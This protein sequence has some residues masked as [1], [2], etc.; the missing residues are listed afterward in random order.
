MTRQ[1]RI[2]FV[3][4]AAAYA[5]GPRQM[6]PQDR[7][8]TKADVDQMM[9]SLS[10]WGRW[11]ETDE[12]GALNLITEEKRREA[13]TLVREGYS[14]SLSRDA[15]K[16]PSDDSPAFE[17]R[18]TQTGVDPQSQSALDSYSVKY[19]G[20][21]ITHIDALCHTFYQGRMYNGF[22][23][24]E[25]TEKG[26][27]KL[28][29]NRMRDGIF[30]RAVLMDFPKLFGVK[31]LKGQRAI[32][33]SDLEAWEKRTGIKVKSGDAIL[34]RT[35]RWARRAE[36]GPWKI[37]GDSAGL[38]AS[39]LPWL[40][41]RDIAVAGSDFS[42]GVQPSGVDGVADP[43]HLVLIVGM[44]VPILDNLDLEALSKAAASRKRWEFLLT[45]APLAVEGGTGSPLNPIATF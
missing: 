15:A 25:V 16:E 29:V 21:S 10:N 32:Y 28:A 19:H 37:V 6:S 39:C 8:F 3:I 11:G 18:M 9:T 20:Y 2:L 44:G 27:A 40:K 36:K 7:V 23:Q 13:A 22:S 41:E 34:I 4:C 43:L 26:A 31:Y 35:G 42:L 45:A 1:I 38:H 30:T 24:R 14:I 5:L 17:H 33:P 12:L